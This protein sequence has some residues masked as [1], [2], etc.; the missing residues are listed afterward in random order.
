MKKRIVFLTAVLLFAVLLFFLKQGHFWGRE[1]KPEA[2]PTPEAEEPQTLKNAWILSSGEDSITF[3]FEG[4]E[5]KLE[6]KGRLQESLSS[7]VADLTVQGKQIISLVLKPDKITAKVLRADEE[8]IELEGYGELEFA[9]GWR[10]YRLYDGLGEEPSEKLLIGSSGNEFILENGKVCA[11]L[12]KEKPELETIRVLIGT[13]GF[14][15][16]YHDSVQITSD[17]PY[18][19]S[20]GDNE[21]TFEAG[22]VCTFTKESF[23]E[24]TGRKKIVS[25]AG[26]G[27][28][29]LLSVKRAEGTPSYRGSL[30]V[31][32]REDGLLIIN[33][34]TIEEY[35]YAVLP[36]EM[37]SRFEKEALKAQ[38]ICARSYA[39]TELLANRYAEY[40]AHVDDSVSCQVYNNIAES[41]ASILAVKDTHGQ[42]LMYDGEVAQ[43]YY[44][45]TSC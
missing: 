22:A 9:K 8:R 35:L 6:T 2:T 29:T 31:D 21:K 25:E 30:E 36:S 5:R 24:E 14:R 34:L 7:C 10:L 44:F 38:A 19:V 1:E 40:G 43:C 23:L 11:A 4:E 39:Y 42:V 20:C 13:E 37:P 45:S 32:C 28:I 41:E 33:E 12:L 15:G 18:K 17:S 26:D 27:K 16:F 3:F